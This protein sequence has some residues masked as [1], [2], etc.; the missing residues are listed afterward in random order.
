MGAQA[1]RQPLPDHG[2]YLAKVSFSHPDGPWCGLSFR[3]KGGLFWP[4][5]GTTWSWSPEIGA[6][7]RHLHVEIVLRDLWVAHRQYDSRPFDWVKD[8]YE[9]RRHSV[10]I[11]VDIR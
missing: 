8:V 6:A 10:P 1:P 5:Q 9:E 3:K 7:Q 11:R 2:I 4:L